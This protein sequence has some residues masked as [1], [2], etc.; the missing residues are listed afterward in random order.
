[1]DFGSSVT[2]MERLNWKSNDIRRMHSALAR[3]PAAM[4]QNMAAGVLLEQMQ[5]AVER[6]RKADG[7]RGQQVADVARALEVAFIRYAGDC[8]KGDDEHVRDDERVQ[9]RR[10]RRFMHDAASNVSPARERE[11]EIYGAGDYFFHLNLFLIM[12]CVTTPVAPITSTVDMIIAATNGSSTA[13]TS[14]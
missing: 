14:L 10:L 5:L 8:E 11:A 9:E 3:T 12:R 4:P 1:M 2:Y 13:S 6:Y 7:R